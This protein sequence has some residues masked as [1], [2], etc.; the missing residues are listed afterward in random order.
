MVDTR[1]HDAVGPAQSAFGW[2]AVDEMKPVWPNGSLDNQGQGGWMGTTKREPLDIESINDSVVAGLLRMIHDT[3]G[4]PVTVTAMCKRTRVSRRG[5]E[6]RFR[7]AMGCSPMQAVRRINLERAA[8]MLRETSLSI[9]EIA[10]HCCFGSS[11]HLSVAFKQYYGACPSHFRNH[12]R[13]RGSQR[14]RNN[15]SP[16][17]AG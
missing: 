11:V 10:R 5:L 2:R 15:R 12:G 3:V 13:Q 4:R 9:K 16:R 1:Y 8:G 14:S 7:A 17:R 6:M